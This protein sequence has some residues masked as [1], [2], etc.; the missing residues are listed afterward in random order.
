[1]TTI[2]L[3]TI[4]RDL[5][6]DYEDG[7]RRVLQ[8]EAIDRLVNDLTYPAETE[9]EYLVNLVDVAI[10]YVQ[11]GRQLN[12]DQ[13]PERAE[14]LAQRETYLKQLKF[15]PRVGQYILA[16]TAPVLPLLESGNVNAP[17]GDFLSQEDLDAHAANAV[18]HHE[19]AES[20]VD[21]SV[22]AADPN[23]H[24]PPVVVDLSSYATIQA[25]ADS[26][27]DATI[28]GNVLSFPRRAGVTRQITIPT[29]TAMADGV[30]VSAEVNVAQEVVTV[31]TSTGATVQWDLT[32]ILSVVRGLITAEEI[33]RLQHEASPH[34]TDSTARASAQS[35]LD[36]ILAHTSAHPTGGGEA[37]SPL[38]D[39]IAFTSNLPLQPGTSQINHVW[40]ATTEG[41]TAGVMGVGLYVQLPQ[42]NPPGVVGV[43]LSVLVGDN[44]V[45][46]VYIPYET[47]G[48]N[49]SHR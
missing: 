16:A 2:N 19:S 14:R 18:A 41:Q 7:T 47:F 46:Q 45:D 21:F 10:S 17:S 37:V 29:G 11:A 5:A 43:V 22:H 35:A 3:Y 23:A 38:G 25:I 39:I 33:A 13:T 27:I 30:I 48:V 31:T 9:G 36:A 8:N 20:E 12:T 42:L 4:V 15:T 44:I 1:M 28:S 6:V 32:P 26:L 49:L 24:H 40:N 34:N